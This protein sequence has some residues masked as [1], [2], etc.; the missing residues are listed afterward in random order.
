M[1]FTRRHQE[2]YSNTTYEPALDDSNNIF[3]F[4]GDHNNNIS[5]KF[6]QKITGKTGNGGKKKCWNNGSVIISKQSLENTWN[7]FN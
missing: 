1:I 5:F 7:A 2:V 3:D 6:K 4:S